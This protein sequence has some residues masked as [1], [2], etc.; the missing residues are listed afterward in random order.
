M[1]R[2]IIFMALGV[3]LVLNWSSIRDYGDNLFG[4][5]DQKNQQIE[6]NQELNDNSDVNNPGKNT[7]PKPSNSKNSAPE[8]IKSNRADRLF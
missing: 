2:A 7:L 5:N 6:I 4:R 8:D 1:V 3:Y